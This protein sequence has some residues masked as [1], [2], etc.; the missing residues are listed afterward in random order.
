MR[1]L[2]GEIGMLDEQF[3]LGKSGEATR[4]TLANS[5][6]DAIRNQILTG[7]L[8]DG[9]PIKQDDLA[10]E[11]GVSRIPVREALRQLSAEG[12]IDL[13]PHR[14]ASV[15]G[16]SQA[17]LLER[18]ELRL[19]IEP[20][21]IKIAIQNCTASDIERA[22]EILTEYRNCAKGD[23]AARASINCRF[24]IALY[25]PSGR[26]STVALIEKL[27]RETSRYRVRMLRKNG[28]EKATAEHAELLEQFRRRDPAN[29]AALLKQHILRWQPALLSM[30]RGEQ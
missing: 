1:T 3:A 27:M 12:L 23:W 11:L 10:E 7:V 28:F 4:V 6:A 24:H 14:S 15:K 8:R 30:R 25:Q 26:K 22:D 18:I 2:G 17:E 20:R 21:I 19:W 9:E 29:G 13:S 16:L 5:V